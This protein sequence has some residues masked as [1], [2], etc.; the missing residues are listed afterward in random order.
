MNIHRV[1]AI[2]AGSVAHHNSNAVSIHV[3]TEE[4]KFDLTLFNLPTEQADYL[5]R[6]LSPI[7]SRVSE[8]SIRADERAKIA[9]R[10][11]LDI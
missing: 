5:S 6:V 8:E 3:E 7:A 9:T 1:S 2:R 10:L 4:G 11:G